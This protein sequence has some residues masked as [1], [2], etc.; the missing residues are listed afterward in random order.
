MRLVI[1]MQ[2]AQ[3]ESRLRG[4]GRYSLSL[5]RGLLP[6]AVNHEVILL[7][8]SRLRDTADAIIKEFQVLLPRENIKTF[9]PLPALAWSDRKNL[10]RARTMEPVREALLAELNP[11]V[12]LLTSFFEGYYD[13]ALVS[14]G[15]YRDKVV[16]AVIQYDL[17]PAGHPEYLLQEGEREFY[18]RKFQQLKSADLFLAISEASRQEAIEKLG[19]DADQV[20]N[21]GA[22]VGPEFK[23][24]YGSPTARIK[25]LSRLGISGDFILYVPGGFDPRKNFKRLFMAFAELPMDLR[26]RYRLV[27]TGPMGPAREVMLRDMAIE[28]GLSHGDLHLVGYV[29]EEELLSLYRSTALFVFPSLQEGFGLPVLEAISCGAPAI[30]SNTSSLPE[31]VGNKEA[32]FD[33]SDFESIA[34]LMERSL[35]DDDFRIALRSHGLNQARQF[36]WS[37]A[38]ALALESLEE[39]AVNARARNPSAD[40][41]E[42]LPEALKWSAADLGQIPNEA[43]LQSLAECLVKNLPI[44]RPPYFFVDVT[45]VQ[46]E[47][48]KTGIQRVVRSLLIALLAAPPQGYEVKPV[49]YDNHGR[50][51]HASC[52]LYRFAGEFADKDELVDFHSGDIYLG[53]DFNIATTPMAEALFR[54]LARQGVRL[55]F[56]IYDMLPILNSGWWPMEMAPRF[57]RWLRSLASVADTVCCI[58]A[59][60]ADE[61][62]EWLEHAR[63]SPQYSPPSIRH[64]HLGGDLENSAPSLGWPENYQLALDAIDKS[65]TFLMVGTVEPR[66]GHAEV[67]DAFEQLWSQGVDINLFI[68]GKAGW[69]VERLISRIQSHNELGRKLFW[70]DDAS[71]ECLKDLYLRS[72]CLIAASEGEGFGL[73]LIEAAKYGVPII[74]RDIPVF[75]EIAQDSAIYFGGP[76]NDDL[77]STLT[78]WLELNDAGMAPGSHDLPWLTWQESAGQLLDALCLEPQAA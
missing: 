36:S 77:C 41:L 12:V 18:E 69:M 24:G 62:T 40:V 10:W 58:S 20:V 68:V 67:L 75:R 49:Y 37:N 19:V 63:V 25:V 8:N 6:I 11:D 66:K 45:E 39:L 72:T 28:A 14:L 3:S 44:K 48:S 76:Q 51:R 29:S 70:F 78:R 17:I 21:I 34:R 2:G 26:Q 32:L 15:S 47:D 52:F 42:V 13:D 71:D 31:V 5:V 53:L 64:F 35:T 7:V 1:D 74:A 27:I 33:P 73:P 46:R 60:V 54:Q 50:Y 57:E 59:A 30:A 22:A 61:V 23:V 38:A 65:P 4:I 43:Q 16:T 55:C 56:V 9:E